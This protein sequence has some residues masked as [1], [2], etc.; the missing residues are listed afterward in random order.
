MRALLKKL[1]LWALSDGQSADSS[2]AAVLDQIAKEL[3]G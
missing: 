3:K 2:Q 1:I